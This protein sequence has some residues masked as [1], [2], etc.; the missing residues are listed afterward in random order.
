MICKT[1]DILRKAAPLDC[2]LRCYQRVYDELQM[3]GNQ[4]KVFFNEFHNLFLWVSAVRVD[5]VKIHPL[6]FVT[7]III[8]WC[9]QYFKNKIAAIA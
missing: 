5:F 6:Q 1:K 7:I 9:K 8:L 3:N 2:A 4:P